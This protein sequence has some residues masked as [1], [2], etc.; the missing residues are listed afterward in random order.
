MEE[1]LPFGSQLFKQANTL[2][3][4]LDVSPAYRISVGD[5][6]AVKMWGARTYESVLAVDVQGNIFIPEIG[7][8]QVSGVQ[9]AHLNSVV[10]N[11]V[12]QV[13]TDSV[14]LY[15]NLLGTQPIGVFVTG[16]VEYPGHYPG[17]RGDTVLYF[18]N[19]AGGISESSGSYRNIV[20]KRDA[21]VVA[22]IDLYKFLV[23]GELPNIE[24]QDNDTILVGSQYPTVS[25]VGEVRNSYKFEFDPSVYTGN[26]ILSLASPL[27][28]ASHVMLQGVR[29][30]E[31]IQK[32]LPIEQVRISKL[33]PGD[34]LRVESDQA[35]REIIVHVK[36]G[37]SGP[38]TFSLPSSTL[39]GQV[40]NLIK[41]DPLTHDV[42]SIYLR[43][44]SVA[45]RQKAAI[46]QSLY[47]LQRSVLTASSESST[48]SAIRAQEAQLIDRFVQQA[49]TVEPEGRVV[50]TGTDWSNI[51]LENGDEIVIPEHSDVVMISGEVKVPQ[52]ILW[53]A[54]YDTDDYIRAAGGSSNRGDSDRLIVVQRNGAVHDGSEPLTKGDHIMVL[55]RIDTKLFAMFRDLVEITYRIALSAAVVLDTN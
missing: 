21:Q 50:L 7:P 2:D 42:N 13:F 12:S 53:R 46:E 54:G 28:R 35:T 49:K 52:T 3:K 27:G 5:R 1:V 48:G 23:H 34:T 43:R 24:F 32:Y 29:G 25:V 15:T 55:P 19:R 44:K 20:I 45:E 31:A 39:L 18:L 10:K 37:T 6:I 26:D 16:A 36:G 41:V 17:G 30:N 40:A 22:S 11:S 8:I 38:A 9:N 47:E 14:K 33:A 51:H 4:N